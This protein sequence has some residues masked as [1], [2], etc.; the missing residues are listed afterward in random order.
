MTRTD[1]TNRR[2][3]RQAVRQMKHGSLNWG[4]IYTTHGFITCHKWATCAAI[5]RLRLA[6]IRAPFTDAGG[7]VHCPISNAQ[8]GGVT[9]THTL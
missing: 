5:E 3:I 8:A 2:A 4:T 1:T 6:L 9:L 7:D